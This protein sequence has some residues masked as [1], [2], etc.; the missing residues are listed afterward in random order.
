MAFFSIDLS[1]YCKQSCHFA[2]VYG[3]SCRAKKGMDRCTLSIIEWSLSPE[4]KINIY[5]RIV[6]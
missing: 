4:K 2:E 5:V 6:E 1:P 3:W